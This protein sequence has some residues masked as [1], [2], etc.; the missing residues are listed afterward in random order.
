MCILALVLIPIFMRNDKEL[1]GQLQAKL[2]Q[3]TSEDKTNPQN[4]HKV[5]MLADKIEKEE[6]KNKFFSLARYGATAAVS[7]ALVISVV[8]TSLYYC[9][10][11]QVVR[12]YL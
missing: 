6:K 3:L 5:E 10:R 12:I 2:A 9:L 1:L 4:Y 11:P 8:N 7:V